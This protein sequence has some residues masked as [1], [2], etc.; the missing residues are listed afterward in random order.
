M[1]LK[2]RVAK[3]WLDMGYTHICKDADGE[4]TLIYNDGCRSFLP[5]PCLRNGL[6]LGPFAKSRCIPKG[7]DQ[8]PPWT[9]FEL[10]SL[11][12]Q[13]KKFVR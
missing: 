5:R 7:W 1:K 10:H 4:W 8:L 3:T 13:H 12:N 11:A 9:I 2:K 6:T